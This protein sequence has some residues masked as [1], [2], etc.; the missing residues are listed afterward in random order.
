M[1]R[2][3]A[4]ALA[5]LVALGTLA[6]AEEPPPI[7]Q[8]DQ[9]TL[10]LLGRYIYRDDQFAWKASDIL[11]AKL[12]VDEAK[13]ERL[14]GLW[15]TH[16]SKGPSVVRFLRDGDSGPE[17]AYDVTFD[18]D[19]PGVLS[20]PQVRTLSE[21]ELAQYRARKLALSNIPRPCSRR[22]NTVAMEDVDGNWLVWALAATTTAGEMMYGGHYRFTISK[23][24]NSIIQ[25]DALSRSCMVIPPPDPSLGQAVGAFVSQLVSNIPVETTLW[26]SLQHKTTIYVGTGENETW[27]VSN[28]TMT[29]VDSK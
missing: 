8:F 12:P 5:A 21:P 29:R 2:F 7:R 13:K 22:Y 10:V 24:G 27:A 9:Q 3:Y 14:N 1:N 23:D 4:A 26:L 16:L 15:I 18:G 20:V 11:M 25:R 19:G 17:A 6:S 28:G